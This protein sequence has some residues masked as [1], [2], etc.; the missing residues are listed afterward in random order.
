MT[1]SLSSSVERLA[2]ACMGGF[3]DDL[4]DSVDLAPGLTRVGYA[5][6]CEAPGVL[7]FDDCSLDSLA[8]IHTCMRGDVRWPRLC[9]RGGIF[10]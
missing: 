2:K 10:R 1:I 9:F 6:T 4:V 5:L 8:L 3:D 7:A